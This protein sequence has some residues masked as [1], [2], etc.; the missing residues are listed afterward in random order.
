MPLTPP[1]PLPPP[2]NVCPLPLTVNAPGV[3]NSMSA[4]SSVIE[5]CPAMS[6]IFVLAPM[7]I[8]SFTE[9]TVTL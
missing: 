8:S 2:K 9:I 1:P 5:L 3:L 6:S 7:R 4:P